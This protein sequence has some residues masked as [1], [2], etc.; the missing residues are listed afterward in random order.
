MIKSFTPFLRFVLLAFFAGILAACNSVNSPI[1]QFKG[2]SAE[3]IY[4]DGIHD[5]LHR[6]YSGASDRFEA[7][8]ALYP[9]SDYTQQAQLDIIYA[10]YEQEDIASAIVAAD[11]YIHLYPNG[12][13]VDYAYYM[14]GLSEM[15]QHI[16]ILEHF[17]PSDPA[18]RDVS[19]IQKA[20]MDFDILLKEFPHSAYTAD[21]AQRMVYIRNVLAQYELETAE[22]YYQR[23]MYVAAIN[24]AN[25]VL[26]HYQET[27][28]IPQA[29]TVLVKAYHQLGMTQQEQEA[30]ALI[31]LNF[32]KMVV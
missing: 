12:T 7:L 11:H 13:N 15:Y 31:H 3:K 18:S 21:A 14:R 4:H 16:G 23:Q 17:F 19:S 10:Y 1:D 20:F 25:E 5:M 9:F 28:S 26:S 29:L 2:Q 8:D 32:P 27:P 6:D 22:Y 24:R 30:R